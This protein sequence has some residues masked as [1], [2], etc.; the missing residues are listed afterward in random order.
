MSEIAL[1]LVK[2]AKEWF[3]KRRRVRKEGQFTLNV[4][5]LIYYLLGGWQNSLHVL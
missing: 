2:T 1:Q 5:K 3:N 4:T